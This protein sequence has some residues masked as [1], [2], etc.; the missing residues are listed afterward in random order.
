MMV[1]GKACY[2]IRILQIQL[3]KLMA[4]AANLFQLIQYFNIRIG[5]VIHN[6]HLIAGIMQLH[7]GVRA[8]ISCPPGNQYFLHHLLKV[9]KLLC[10]VSLR[11]S[12]GSDL[13]YS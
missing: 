13:K 11:A 2:C 3:H 4:L 6:N 8:N 12:C 7:N 1:L 5:K 9:S 10:S